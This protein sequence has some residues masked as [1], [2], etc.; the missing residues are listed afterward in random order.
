MVYTGKSLLSTSSRV[1]EVEEVLKMLDLKL[2]GNLHQEKLGGGQVSE[3]ELV[4]DI[5]TPATS[6]CSSSVKDRGKTKRKRSDTSEQVAQTPS[7]VAKLEK[8]PDILLLEM[9]KMLMP[10]SEN[11][12]LPCNSPG[13]DVIISHAN[14][15]KH[16]E[17]HFAEHEKKPIPLKPKA[18]VILFKCDKCGKG[19]KFR[20]ALEN[21]VKDCKSRMSP[22][23]TQIVLSKRAS[24]SSDSLESSI[25]EKIIN[26]S[27]CKKNV[28][29]AWHLHPS[30][31]SCVEKENIEQDV[32]DPKPIASPIKESPKHQR[33]TSTVSNKNKQDESKV[34][35]HKRCPKCNE[36]FVS[37]WNMRCHLSAIHFKK[38]ILEANPG[39]ICSICRKDY[40]SKTEMLKHI[41]GTH[42]EVLEKILNKEGLSLDS[43]VS[44]KK[45]VDKVSNG[46][47]CPKCGE[48]FDKRSTMKI[49]VANRHYMEKLTTT[50][51]GTQCTICDK[52]LQSRKMLLKH[53]AI[54]HEKILVFLL[55]KEGLILPP[56]QD[57][58][59]Q[60]AILKMK[61]KQDK[62]LESAVL[63]TEPKY[64]SSE[65]KKQEEPKLISGGNNTPEKKLQE[66]KEYGFKCPKCDKICQNYSK[67]KVHIGVSHY[68]KKLSS[69]HPGTKCERCNKE[70]SSHRNLVQHI[71]MK[72]D[73]VLVWLLGR[74]GLYLPSKTGEEPKQISPSK[75]KET[76]NDI[77]KPRANKNHE[78]DT[79]SKIHFGANCQICSQDISHSTLV[80]M[81][82][83]LKNHFKDKLKADSEGLEEYQC[84][85]CKEKVDKSLKNHSK[86]LSYFAHLRKHPE[87]LVKYLKVE[88]LYE[89]PSPSYSE[90]EH[91]F[92]IKKVRVDIKM[93]ELIRGKVKLLDIDEEDEE[94]KAEESESEPEPELSLEERMK[95]FL[96][97]EDFTGKGVKAL[98]TH[99]SKD[100]YRLEL[101]HNFITR[102]GKTWSHDR[103]CQ[104][105]FIP[106][107]SREEYIL[108][109]GVE[110]RMVD[111]ELPSKYRLPADTI[112][113]V[114]LPF[115]F[116]SHL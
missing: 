100:H 112:V 37:S 97:F 23:K 15:T 60:S 18:G 26:C 34:G 36:L 20:K 107:Q 39:M 29:S 89:E 69:V 75:N 59:L 85:V 93:T 74:D 114:R 3:S 95:C 49:H 90:G 2:P 45:V 84:F 78:S 50:Y 6:S 52:E 4:V 98:L 96:C 68:Y 81:R 65:G 56:K 61:P 10:L 8:S 73:K 77:A 71:L 99:Y 91:G 25:S 13:C 86:S 44:P 40:S 58:V 67:L 43:S 80:A 79:S 12:C 51:P 111:R 30:R 92:C 88:N 27:V 32:D 103:K 116:L 104:E 33:E 83:Y 28:P 47:K 21:H 82:H 54:G 41:G 22:R 38:E 16:F 1:K 19:F 105:C 62:V 66:K 57:Q 70:S 102:S 48:D 72:H 76:E 64:G 42:K 87:I 31:H 94:D 110:H 11:K 109:I 5:D 55:G 7:K 115:N 113:K 17:G 14:M 106:V 24:F 101:E 9:A 63:K 108:H 46:F 35:K 53:I